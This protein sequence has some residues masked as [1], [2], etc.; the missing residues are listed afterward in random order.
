[1]TRVAT[2][3]VSFEVIKEQFAGKSHLESA[4]SFLLLL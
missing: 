4:Y 3:I 1:M 2:K